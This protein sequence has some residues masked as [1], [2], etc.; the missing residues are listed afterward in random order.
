MNRA[1]FIDRD[2]TLIEERGF[3]S[4][5]R[6]VELIPGAA[7]A[8]R[9]M[10]S[11]GFLRIVI[12]NQSGVG[13]GYFDRDSVEAINR[14]LKELLAERGTG[15]DD[16]LYCPHAPDDDCMCRKPR[17]GLLLEASLR[18][19]I[20]LKR[21]YMIG[22][23]DSDIGAI[24]SVGGKGVLVLTGY[25]EETWRRWRW[26]HRP[27]FVAR[28][29]LEAVYWIMGREMQEGKIVLDEELLKMLVCPKCKGK[30]VVRG[31]GLLCR[32]CRLLYPVEDGIPVMLPEEAKTVEEAS[33]G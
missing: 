16:V 4:D 3:I 28:D 12:S 14:R 11:M 30:L 8:L 9:L 21:S 6:Q 25:G 17:P 29:I 27:D 5:P 13:R 24:A 26:G 19:S 18:H 31:E 7:E 33:D 15:L 1:I 2:G 22:D 10:S 23:R 20:D 32:G